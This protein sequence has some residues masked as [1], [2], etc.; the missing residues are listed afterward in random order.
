MERSWNSASSPFEMKNAIPYTVITG[1]SVYGES[2]LGE[3][4]MQTWYDKPY[5]T[6]MGISDTMEF[7]W[8]DVEGAAALAA[9]AL[10]AVLTVTI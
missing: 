2:Y 10:A 8:Y 3:D 1:Y 4:L 6:Y 5:A 9:G 7:I